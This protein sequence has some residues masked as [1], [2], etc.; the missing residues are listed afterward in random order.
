MVRPAAL[1]ALFAAALAACEA[2]APACTSPAT[3]E[4]R[5]L[6]RLIAETERDIARGYTTRRTASGASVNLC[7]GGADN[8]VGLSFCTDGAR[9]RPVAIDAA[10]ERRK[11][12]GLMERREALRRQE[13]GDIAACRRRAA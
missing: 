9:S 6:D 5:V 11:L 2:T 1:P 10:T 3:R 7:V 13:A 8:G 12:A 4:L